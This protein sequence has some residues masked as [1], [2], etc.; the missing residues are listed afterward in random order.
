MKK[1]WIFH[2]YKWETYHTAPVFVTGFF[3]DYSLERRFQEG[4][5]D[6][7]A[8]KFREIDVD[9]FAE[10][11]MAFI[12]YKIGVAKKLEADGRIEDA[13]SVLKV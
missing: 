7:G 3:Q 9:I 1:H 8:Y 13:I 4:H 11:D 5:C 6:C 12:D 2:K 10:M